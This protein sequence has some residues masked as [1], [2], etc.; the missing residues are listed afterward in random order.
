VNNS[1]PNIDD[2]NTAL[3][4]AKGYEARQAARELLAAA[5]LHELTC[6]RMEEDESYDFTGCAVR[7]LQGA[8]AR[9]ELA[10]GHKIDI[11]IR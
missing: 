11:R 3:A 2:A 10:L 6:R 5:A 9:W 4:V 1:T 7:A 8:L